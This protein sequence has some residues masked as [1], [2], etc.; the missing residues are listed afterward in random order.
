MRLLYL[1][2]PVSMKY[3]LCFVTLSMARIVYTFRVIFLHA[4]TA[5]YELPSVTN[6]YTH[7]YI[8]TRDMT[9]LP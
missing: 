7:I 8:Y 3:Q 4:S 1:V 6:I 2:L 5:E 9:K